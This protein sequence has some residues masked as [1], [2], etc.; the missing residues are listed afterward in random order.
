MLAIC[1]VHGPVN[2]PL[3]GG[4]ATVMIRNVTVS[5]PICGRPSRVPDGMHDL[6]T[7]VVRAFSRAGAT[8][9]QV[10]RFRDIAASVQARQ[11]TQ[12]QAEQQMAELGGAFLTLWQWLNANG[13]AIQTI[14][15]IIA[16]FLL[17]Y[18]QQS[19]N[20]D[21][22][23]LQ[24][25]SG[26]QIAVEQKILS[27]LRKQN[28]PAPEPQTSPPPMLQRL[29]VGQPQMQVK[30]RSPNRHERRAG[31]ARNRRKPLVP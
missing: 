27:E 17:I 14:V 22:Q 10:S 23:K 15:A 31:K 7:G 26:K 16:L 9:E 30:E 20:S 6:V 21:A 1:P 13:T 29:Q 12:E 18:F 2:S 5:C 3:I 28:V 11:A 25:A 24:A 19:S 4:T 8:K